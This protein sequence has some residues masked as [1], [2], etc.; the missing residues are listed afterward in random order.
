MALPLEYIFNATQEIAL[1]P[2]YPNV[3]LMVVDSIRSSTVPLR[4]VPKMAINWTMPTVELLPYF[5]AV[6][7]LTG[8]RIFDALG[9][10]VPIGLI[11]SQVRTVVGVCV[12]ALCSTAC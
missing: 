12:A 2:K 10:K 7:W 4:D 3:R 9:G 1:A 11:E 6:C 5:S 8:R